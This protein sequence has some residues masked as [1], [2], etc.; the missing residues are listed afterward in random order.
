MIQSLYANINLL[1][2]NENPSIRML[3]PAQV[4]SPERCPGGIPT[5]WNEIYL[6]Q[7]VLYEME[8]WL[9]ITV[10]TILGF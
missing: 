2:A 7:Y 6:I 5:R 10:I 4:T 9:Q 3:S 8:Y 1:T